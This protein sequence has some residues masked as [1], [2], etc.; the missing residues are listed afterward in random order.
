MQVRIAAAYGGVALTINSAPS[1]AEVAAASP[2]G[3]LPVLRTPGGEYVFQSNAILRYVAGLNESANLVG[4]AGLQ[5]GEV[6]QWLEFAATEL[7]VPAGVLGAAAPEE[8]AGRARAHVLASLAV[9]N[10][11]LEKRTFMVG[12]RV[13]LADISLAVACVAVFKRVLTPSQ[14]AEAPHACRWFFTCVNQP[15]FRSVLG[16]LVVP[17]GAPPVP[18]GGGAAAAAA[19]A[20][21]P[22]GAFMFPE[23]AR[24][25][26]ASSHD[27]IVLPGVG[28]GVSAPGLFRRSRVRVRE[29]L[30]NGGAGF[31]GRE[32]TVAGW[33]KTTRVQGKGTFAF[34]ELNDGSTPRH[35]Q[36]VVSEEQTEG[37]AA[38][39]A[40]GG[41][42]AS[43]VITG[44][45]IPSPA[46]GQP[47]ELQA[48]RAHVCGTVD[49]EKYPLAKKFHKPETLREIAHLRPRTNLIS[50]VQR[51]RNA[52]AFATHQFFQE[53]GFQYVHTPLITAADCEGAGE[54]FAVS[55]ILPSDAKVSA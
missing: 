30:A 53:R 17:G 14:R 28:T 47:C 41:V 9:L 23:A 26:G 36:V 1:A 38:A 3:K 46:E 20:S 18:A 2:S 48:T 25:K 34:V 6:D 27:A 13:T 55:T 37:F 54:M 50:A 16:E 51:V 32:I 11:H 31:I 4:G 43:M 33:V 29:V 39:V 24:Y 12:E 52:C 22:A 5:G 45:L 40:A 42:G 35:L 7:E 10:S 8:A 15:H 44:A 21:A 19:A 49:A